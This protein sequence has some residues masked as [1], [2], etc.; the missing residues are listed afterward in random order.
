MSEVPSEPNACSCAMS[1]VLA[2]TSASRAL[3][4]RFNLIVSS[5]MALLPPL[6]QK[7]PYYGPPN[8]SHVIQGCKSYKYIGWRGHV[9]LSSSVQGK[10]Q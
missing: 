8:V 5:W 2:T 6:L 1:F 9:K 3:R 7:L 4:M 10:H